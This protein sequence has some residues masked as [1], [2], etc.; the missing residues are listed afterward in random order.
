M[1]AGP[2]QGRAPACPKGPSRPRIRAVCEEVRALLKHPVMK[3]HHALLV[4]IATIPSAGCA[5]A[6]AD[7]NADPV[8]SSSAEANLC[9][10][11]VGCVVR[12]RSTLGRPT[13]LVLP[14]PE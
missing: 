1:R 10:P 7:S 2:V 4:A 14:N 13:F 11:D 12:D 5:V 8:A 6:A 9:P 3:T